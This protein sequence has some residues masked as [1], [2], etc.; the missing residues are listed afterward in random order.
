MNPSA[1]R[2]G[3]ACLTAELD[4]WAAAGRRADLWLRDDDATTA[5]PALARLL[6][7]SAS[8]G[9]R[10]VVAAVPSGADDHLAAAVTGRGSVCVHGIAHLNHAGPGE[11][12]QELHPN[13]GLDEMIAQLQA[14]L[15]AMRARFGA[16]L[17]PVLVPPWNRLD[18]R[19]TPHLPAI[20]FIGVS[21]F[22]ARTSRQ[23]APGLAQV[24]THVDLIEW[25]SRRSGRPGPLVARA[26]ADALQCAR[27]GAGAGEP[28][29]I[30]SHHL[31]H[32]AQAWTTLEMLLNATAGHRGVRWCDGNTLFS[33][34][35]SL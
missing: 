24:N 29:G 15:T 7:M 35:E 12:K 11:K 34:V 26:L 27:A 14:A 19:L 31:I 2:D 16:A 21:G 10:P 4:R 8:H 33:E 18:P 3:L 20:G 1:G 32:D 13:R 9:V 22:K 30:L 25:G 6:D 17:L 28:I 5:T 23:A